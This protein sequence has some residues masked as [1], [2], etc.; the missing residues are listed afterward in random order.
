MYIDLKV[1]V[2]KDC[3]LLQAAFDG[4][5]LSIQGSA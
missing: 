2:F 5:G 1:S 3:G 4:S